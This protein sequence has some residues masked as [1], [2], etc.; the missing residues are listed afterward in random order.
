MLSRKFKI[1][2]LKEYLSTVPL[3]AADMVCPFGKHNPLLDY[4]EEHWNDRLGM[5]PRDIPCEDL[6]GSFPELGDCKQGCPCQT[7]GRGIAY[8]M[9]EKIVKEDR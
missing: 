5:N 3:L 6:C 1:Q 8:L 2:L 4:D 9:A 7:L